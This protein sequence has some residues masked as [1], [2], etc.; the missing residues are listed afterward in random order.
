V[1][2]GWPGS[3]DFE[4]GYHEPGGSFS[5]GA[6]SFG[7]SLWLINDQNEVQTTSDT[8]PLDQIRQRL[9]WSPA[10]DLPAVVAETAAYEAS[11]TATGPGAWQLKLKAHPG[12]SATLCLV[13]RSVGPAGGPVRSLEFRNG[14]LWVNRRWEMAIDPGLTEVYGGEEGGAQWIASRHSLTN[15]SGTNGWGYAVFQIPGQRAWTLQVQDRAGAKLPIALRHGRALA[16]TDLNL[17]DPTF[18]TCLNA[19]VAHLLMGLVAGE[20]RPVDP[21]SCPV[22]W[23][24]DAAYVVSALARAGQ[25]EVARQLCRSLC[26]LDFAGGFG[27]EA[28]APGLALWALNE[29][30]GRLRDPQFKQAVWPHVV[31]KTELLQRMLNAARPVRGPVRGQVVPQFENHPELSLLCEPSRDG[32]INGRVD[33]QRPLLYINAV[34]YRGLLSAVELA[35]WVGNPTADSLW[36]SQAVQMRSLWNNLM[37]TSAASQDHTAISGLWP[38]WMVTDKPGF[39]HLL[40]QRWLA[41]HDEQ[42]R[43]K[44][45]PTRV[46][47]AVAEAHQWLYLGQPARTWTTLDWLLAHQVSPGLF[48]WGD[49]PGDRT[50]YRRWENIRGWITPSLVTPDYRAA[51]ELLLLQLDMLVFVDESLAEPQLVVGAGIPAQWLEQ[52]MHVRGLLTRLGRVDW[53]WDKGTMLVRVGGRSCPVRLGPA[54]PE[55][56]LRTQFVRP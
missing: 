9:E 11:W 15:W 22:N 23:T 56:A 25:V 12:E 31:R 30:A 51:A 55:R 19:Q 40:N 14:H 41:A 6:G 21:L 26:D 29:V 20:T 35:D 45:P 5:P 42:G 1:I 44:A 32:L 37:H 17:P 54:F 47:F 38:T 52:P 39:A 36:R 33:W 49:P 8:Y 48:T 10:G 34:S 3:A 4:K 13:V 50:R 43:R 28:D 2:L 16:G 18:V 24:S 53:T 46:A 27:P 7:I